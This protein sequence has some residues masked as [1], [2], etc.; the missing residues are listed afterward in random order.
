MDDYGHA[1]VRFENDALCMVT[2]SQVTHGRLNDLT[3][4]VDGTTGSLR[5]Q[6]EHPNQMEL[7]RHGQPQ[8]TY[9]RHPAAEYT[10]EWGRD[11]CRIPPGHPEAF[12]EA[13][14]NVYRSAFDAMVNRSQSLPIDP[15]HAPFPTVSVGLLGVEFI[16]QCLASHQAGGQWQRLGEQ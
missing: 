11:A 13:F 16:E 4:E 15:S 10:N 3:L 1:L 6:Q 2:F 12:L 14:A 5:W 8:Q 9:E 7:R